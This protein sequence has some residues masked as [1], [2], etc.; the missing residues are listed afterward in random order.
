MKKKSSST[1]IFEKD[2][3]KREVFSFQIR[4]CQ[5]FFSI[6]LHTMTICRNIFQKKSDLIFPPATQHE[7]KGI[8]E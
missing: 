2:R 3:Y 7:Y 5:T 8:L 6:F 1:A 4:R